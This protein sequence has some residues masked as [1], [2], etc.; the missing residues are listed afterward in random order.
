MKG[1]IL[2]TDYVDELLLKELDTHGYDYDYEPDITLDGVKSIISRYCAVVINTKTKMD[3]EMLDLATGLKLIVRLGSGLDIIDLDYAA[4][5]GIIVERTAEANSN[6][7]GE[8][9]AAMLLALM[10]KLVTANMEVRNMQWNR[11]K[12]RGVELQGM[13]VGIIG[14]GHT[15]PAFAAKLRSFDVKILV[16]DK[17]RQRFGEHIRYI[18]E[19]NMQEIF[20]QSD[21]LSLHIPLTAETQYMVNKDFFEK[22]KKNILFINTSRGK[23]VKTRDLIDA[24]E[25][26]KVKGAALDVLEN[27]KI[28]TYTDEE[29]KMYKKLFSMPNVIVTPHIAGWTEQSKRKIAKSAFDKINKYCY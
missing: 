28:D 29:R 12:N 27:E 21:I 7:V 24:L 17:Y 11:E 18:V 16:F 13:T 8:H 19:S 9:A 5:K 6:A 2:I 15:G 14:F 10:T 22:F 3:R 23:I 4:A 25:S 26:G 20:E 1:K